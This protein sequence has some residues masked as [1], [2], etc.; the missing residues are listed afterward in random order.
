M[1]NIWKNRNSFKYFVLTYI[2]LKTTFDFKK[3]N[4]CDQPA[5]IKLRYRLEYFH[6]FLFFF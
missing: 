1:L 3:K 2:K 4:K 5:K 6:T